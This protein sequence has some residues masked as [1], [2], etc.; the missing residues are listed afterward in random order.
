[1]G[2]LRKVEADLEL[3]A[4]NPINALK[5]YH[6]AIVHLK[7]ASDYVWWAAALEGLAVARMLSLL[8]G[9]ATEN[10]MQEILDDL[11]LAIVNYSKSL[12]R[13]FDGTLINGNSESV[14]PLVFVESVLRLLD[15]KLEFVK[16]R[17]SHLERTD[18]ELL[19]ILLGN[20]L[21]RHRKPRDLEQSSLE[22]RLDINR[23]GSMVELAVDGLQFAE[24]RIR[25]LSKLVGAFEAIG[26]MRKA[27][28]FKRELVG[29]VVEQIGKF[30]GSIPLHGRQELVNLIGEVCR[31]FRVPIDELAHQPVV[32]DYRPGGIEQAQSG[33]KELQLG[34]LMDAIIVCNQL[35]ENLSELKFRLKLNGFLDH[36]GAHDLEIKDDDRR[37]SWLFRSLSH[38]SLNYW[39]PRQII[40]TLELVP[41]SDRHALI[42]YYKRQLLV[43]TPQKLHP[44]SLHV[45]LPTFYYNH[46]HTPTG[47]GRD[48]ALPLK[49][50]RDEP[51]NVLVTLQNPMSIDLE[52]VMICL[53]TIGIPFKAVRTQTVIKSRM[54]KTIALTGVPLSSG[55]LKIKGCHIQL[56]GCAEP[57]EFIL[58][59]GKPKWKKTEEEELLSCEVIE[60]LPFLRVASN[61]EQ[62]ATG[63]GVMVYDG[64]V[65]TIEI[66][67]MNTSNVQADWI[68]VAVQD[69]LSDQMRKTLDDLQSNHLASYERY[70][71]EYELVH[72]PALSV[73]W[74][75][76]IGPRG[77]GWVRLKCLGKTGCRS[78][79]VKIEYDVNGG[80]N[81]K[82]Q[83]EWSIGLSVQKSL[84]VVGFD[85]LAGGVVIIKVHNSAQ[86]G[87]V[88]EVEA[89]GGKAES[90]SFI[91]KSQKQVIQPG[92]THAFFIEIQ[93]IQVTQLDSQKTI[94]ALIDRQ[95]V[96]AQRD[97]GNEKRMGDDGGDNGTD[98]NHNS[99]RLSK[100]KLAQAELLKFW[101]K[102][103]L[104]NTI[105]MEWRELG[106]NK[107]GEVS[108][109]GVHVDQQMVNNLR[110]HE[111]S[112]HMNIHN[113]DHDHNDDVQLGNPGQSCLPR[114]QALLKTDRFYSVLVNIKNQSG[115]KRKID[116]LV[117]VMRL[118]GT[119]IPSK[120]NISRGRET[121]AGEEGDNNES[122]VYLIEG[123][124]QDQDG[125]EVPHRHGHHLN[126][127]GTRTVMLGS[128]EE[129]D[130]F[131][132]DD[133][134]QQIW[135]KICF[136]TRGAFV[137]QGVAIDS[138]SDN[139]DDD[140]D[141]HPASSLGTSDPTHVVVVS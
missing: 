63:G 52:I 62:L 51:I 45:P 139:D 124:V 131:G 120:K 140:D 91:K 53:S 36:H 116:C 18:G 15:F 75:D 70:E 113:D 71:L 90:Q 118:D 68:D 87:Q 78:L 14:E 22:A 92:S 1:M 21:G 82:R 40:L 13:S 133:H 24:D 76:S 93:P 46:N 58:P 102:E 2:R 16:L 126:H 134:E 8:A 94:P 23:I 109:R 57:Q 25:A 80:L 19:R 138:F 33:W 125:P 111:V 84:N 110:S 72:R 83:L 86:G 69:S 42:P 9:L 41:L 101:I 77:T 55:T 74:T 88:F 30:R 108:L 20:H 107:T 106:T 129:D 32:I 5:I 26:F 79:G 29:V 123:V 39:G 31:S 98:K 56:I 121:N 105:K 119:V 44:G 89:K 43:T 115:M 127:G 48:K 96:V 47:I 65:I 117:K 99:K 97:D 49:M 67:L 28:W 10:S 54:V 37:I 35:E 114:P 38:P 112:V 6:E 128:G 141:H 132:H 81:L 50:V 85:S 3:L 104:L 7:S 11:E 66:K 135:I 103:R 130:D 59:I 73:T 27:A 61:C 122:L 4:A 64:E 137:L 12:S 95:F 100:E 17:D 34:V 136:L 60:G